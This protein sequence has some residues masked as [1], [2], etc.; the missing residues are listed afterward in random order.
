MKA[1]VSALR[2]SQLKLYP[3]NL[4]WIMPPEETVSMID[5]NSW[6]GWILASSL[7]L[8]FYDLSKKASV[9]NNSVFPVLFLTTFSGWVTLSVFL[10]CSGTMVKTI[11]I[12]LLNIALLFVKSCIVASSWTATYIALKTMPITCAAPIRA[13]GPLWTLIGAIVVFGEIPTSLQMVG[14]A[15]VFIGCAAFSRSASRE[16]RSGGIKSVLLAFTGTVLG[17]CSALY[18]KH[19]LQGLGL[20]TL[21]VLWWFLGGMC[22][23]YAVAA[24]VRHEGFEWR[25]TIPC[26]GVLLAV[27]DA[28]YFNAISVP[29]AQISVLSLIRRSSIVLT[30]FIGGAVF[31]EKN[32]R[33]KLLALLAILIGVALLC[34][35]R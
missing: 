2:G 35:Y 23:M 13:T 17:S 10:L 18:D 31:K 22:L 32:L 6:L 21:T 33:R 20:G 27:S 11:E 12:S 25:W 14:M 30:F 26:V 5:S 7:G 8:S 34:L 1:G 29:D 3:L 9:R 4:N 16:S 19:L 28:C 15:L 24:A